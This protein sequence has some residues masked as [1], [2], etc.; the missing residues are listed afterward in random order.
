M[1]TQVANLLSKGRSWGHDWMR[2]VPANVNSYHGG[3]LCAEGR[4][5]QATADAW[6]PVNQTAAKSWRRD[7]Q[8][9]VSSLFLTPVKESLPAFCHRSVCHAGEGK[10]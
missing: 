4:V 6:C 10:G 7:L 9:S 2:E 5:N 3:R 1:T 8:M